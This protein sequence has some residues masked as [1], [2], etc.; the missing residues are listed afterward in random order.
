MSSVRMPP[1]PY[2]QADY[3]RP[4]SRTK[5]RIYSKDGDNQAE[6]V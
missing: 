3:A 5:Q 4:G 2:T 6:E 1:L